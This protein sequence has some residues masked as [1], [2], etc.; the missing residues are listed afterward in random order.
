MHRAALIVCLLLVT[1]VA[2][3]LH[4]S[5]TSE[6]R[7]RLAAG[8]LVV[9]QVSLDRGD[10]RFVG[11][12][13]YLVVE[14]DWQRLSAITRDVSR[15]P[16]LF[17]F[18]ASATLLGIDE[19]GVAR[20]R[21]EHRVG[22]VKGAYTTKIAFSEGGRRARFFLDHDADND[23]E[24]AWGFVRFTPLDGGTRTLVTY[25]LLFDLG[26]GFLSLFESP[27][28]RAALQYPRKLADA[29]ALGS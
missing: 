16:E 10:G 14:A 28:C 19:H 23:V 11:G 3:P 29:A 7:E 5:F 26:Q 15:F 18:V 12:L 9:Q 22:M 21:M 20:V 27:I 1:L 4:A 17:P 24:E 2:R 25:A 13:A 8:E 6:E